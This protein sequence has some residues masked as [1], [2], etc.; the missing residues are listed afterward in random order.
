[1]RVWH[2]VY[3][4]V[5]SGVMLHGSDMKCKLLST[6]VS[7]CVGLVSSITMHTLVCH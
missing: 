3:I 2:E 6:V 7:F 1:M 5:D 4:V